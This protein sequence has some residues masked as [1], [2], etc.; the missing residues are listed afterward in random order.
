MRPAAPA[1]RHLVKPAGS[2]QALRVARLRGDAM[3]STLILRG[4]FTV[5]SYGNGLFYEILRNADGK[6]VFLQDSYDVAQF[7]ADVLESAL[8]FAD[9]ITCHYGDDLDCAP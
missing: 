8:P 5:T 9:T 3:R 1:R 6:S 2:R 7:E 4:P